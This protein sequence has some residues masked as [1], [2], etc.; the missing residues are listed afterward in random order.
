[1]RWHWVESIAARM[2]MAAK[3]SHAVKSERWG[4]ED[5]RRENR[6]QISIL[7]PGPFAWLIVFC[8]SNF[9]SYKNSPFVLKKNDVPHGAD[10]NFLF[11]F[12]FWKLKKIKEKLCS[13]A[14]ITSCRL[15]CR[16][17]QMAGSILQALLY[18]NEQQS[19]IFDLGKW[20]VH[21][22]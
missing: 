1:M 11:S 21:H 19:V 16:F 6:I 14:L 8:W 10:G 13:S 22:L 17:N 9:G 20:N 5:K 15:L 2:L 4:A 7:F 12:F 18:I 3:P